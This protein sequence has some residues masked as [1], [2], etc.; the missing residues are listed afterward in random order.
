MASMASRARPGAPPW[1]G[2]ASAPRAAP[3][4]SA[5]SA[6]V[7]ATTRAVNVDA[8]KPWS[9]VRI[10]VLLER[11][12]GRRRRYLARHEA[13][14]VGGVAELGPGVDRVEAEADPV[15]RGDDD[16]D[17]GRDPPA[18]ARPARPASR[19][20]IGRNPSSSPAIDR[21]ARNAPRV[22]PRAWA[23]G[24]EHRQQRRRQP[25]GR[26]DLRRG[27]SASSAGSGRWPTA[28][29]CHTSSKRVVAGQLDGVVAAVVEAARLAVDVADRGVGDG[30]AVEARG[31][32]RSRCSCSRSSTPSTSSSTLIRST[33]ISAYDRRM[34]QFV[35]ATEAARRLG[36]QKATLYAYVSRGV[37]DRRMAADGRTSLYAVDDLEAL[38]GRG[39]RSPAEPRAVDRR[40]D[41]HGGLD[42]RRGR[43]PLPRPRR[44][45]AGR[46]VHVR[47]GRRAP[48]DRRR[49]RPR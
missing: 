31:D 45:R 20:I 11:P 5:R 48:V 29:R 28:T 17:D 4:T 42:A 2:P 1:S 21:A 6:P 26:G 30:N 39:R 18:P 35:G 13:Q 25:A 37:I 19:S 47:A 49:C 16:R 12:G 44:R 36:V 22:A 10:E 43:R 9:T 23:S 40:A 24:A 33:L 27:T 34:T 7:E 3:T 41:R 46:D 14:V 32:S 38:A 15:Q 8:L